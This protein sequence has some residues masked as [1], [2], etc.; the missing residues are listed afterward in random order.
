MAFVLSRL[1]A[2]P[3][4]M[5]HNFNSSMYYVVLQSS[6][7]LCQIYLKTNVFSNTKE[8]ANVLFITIHTKRR[9]DA[10]HELVDKVKRNR[11]GTLRVG[12]F[13]PDVCKTLDVLFTDESLF[14]V[15]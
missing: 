12:F 6:R 10:K 4:R 14:S 15:S 13:H 3:A 1:V 7:F 5:K 11:A 2:A 8:A 9:A